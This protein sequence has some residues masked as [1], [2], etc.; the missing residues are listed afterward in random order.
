MM[1]R[2]QLHLGY[3][4]PSQ[5]NEPVYSILGPEQLAEIDFDAFQYANEMTKQQFGSVSNGTKG[6]E[7]TKCAYYFGYSRLKSNNIR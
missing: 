1:M 6:N 5:K 7:Q 4:K 2:T 3:L